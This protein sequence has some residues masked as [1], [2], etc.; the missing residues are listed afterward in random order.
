MESKTNI[1][2]I[3]LNAGAIFIGT[4]EDSIPFVSAIVSILADTEA[5]ITCYQS[6][7]KQRTTTT[8]F[9][10]TDIGNLQ[11]FII[12]PLTLPYIYFIVQNSSSTNQ[13]YLNFTV[14]YVYTSVSSAKS[15]SILWNSVSTGING[16]SSALNLSLS[17]QSNATFYGNVSGATNLIVQ[18][19]ADGNSYYDSQYKYT[20][21]SAGG[22]GF[23]IEAIPN[24][25]RLVSSSNIIAKIYANYY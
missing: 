8:T 19:S 24:F 15:N 23:N 7:N 18:F 1:T 6:L 14:K 11:S 4:Y 20:I 2:N 9:E 17:T 21:N 3:P 13:T 12:S 22:I 25:C 5:T 10:Y 16:A